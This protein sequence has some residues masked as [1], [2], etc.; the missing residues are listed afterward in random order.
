[1]E[2]TKENIERIIKKYE[3]AIAARMLESFIK[4]EM[5]IKEEEG[6]AR[7]IQHEIDELKKERER[8]INE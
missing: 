7:R 2:L 3:P 6:V 5:A 1:M 4:V 8:L